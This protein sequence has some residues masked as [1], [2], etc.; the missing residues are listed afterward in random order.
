MS[1]FIVSF[2][3]GILF[4]WLLVLSIL[5]YRQAHFLNVF[6]AGVTKKDLISVLKNIAQSLQKLSDEINHLNDSHKQFQK[7]SEKHLQKVGFLRYNPFS[8]TGGDQSFCV[9]FLDQ[10]NHGVIMTSLH[11][12]EQTRLYAKSV[13]DGRVEGF[14]LSKEEDL[15]LKMAMKPGRRSVS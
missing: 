9:C 15:A 12:R 10:N 6:T 5:F 8:D 14:E 13:K 3:A 1:L 4:I 11:S 2:L 7:V